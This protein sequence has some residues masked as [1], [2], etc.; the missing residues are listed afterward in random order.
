VKRARTGDRRAGGSIGAEVALLLVRL[1]QGT[2]GGARR[3]GSLFG[4]ELDPARSV[5]QRIALDRPAA[6]RRDPQRLVAFGPLE[7]R[8]LDLHQGKLF[9]ITAR[10]SM[11]PM[12]FKY[13]TGWNCGGRAPPQPRPGF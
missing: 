10:I 13:H 2:Q 4:S 3:D 9:S 11:A 5:L 1:V 12:R 7:Q 8:V 6:A